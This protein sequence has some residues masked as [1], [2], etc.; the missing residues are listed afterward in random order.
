MEEEHD[1]APQAQVDRS[2]SP[3]S[4]ERNPSRQRGNAPR[5]RRRD[6]NRRRVVPDEGQD[7]SQALAKR[8]GGDTINQQLATPSERAGAQPEG[9]NGPGKDTLKL[10]LDLN[11]EVDIR[12]TAEVHGDVTLSLLDS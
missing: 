12:I 3:E 5:S 11:L 8:E 9:G 10:R 7:D 2:S 6:R 1:Q 4:E